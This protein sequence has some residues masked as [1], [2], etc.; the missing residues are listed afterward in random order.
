MKKSVTVAVDA[1]G[2]D[3]APAEIVKGVVDAVNSNSSVNITLVGIEDRVN[4]ELGKYEYDKSRIQVINA[5]EIIETAEHPVNAIR[6]KKDSSL[7]V[8]LNLVKNGEADAFVS[9]GSTG[10]VLVGAQAIVGRIPGVKRPPLAP[11]LPTAKGPLVLVDCGAN[12]D[13]RPDHLVLFARMGSIYSE[14]VLGIN[15]PKVG[16]ANNG[17]EEEKGNQLVKD[18]FPLLKECEDI[19]FVGSVE[20]KDIPQGNA[21]VVVCDGFVGNA[22]LKMYEGVGAT[23]ISE[24]KKSLMTSFRGKLGGLLIK[25]SL[26]QVLKKYDAT[27][28][29]GAPM[30]GLNGLVVKAHG[31][32]N[33]KEIKNAVHQCIQ[34]VEADINTKIKES[35]QND[36]Q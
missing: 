34:F 28:Y 8:A 30:L 25:P 31:S 4:L 3:N 11:V 5:T 24:I 26:K 21:D 2:G 23:L 15:K 36:N 33:A 35:L 27:E 10:A 1:M 18:T 32:S 14:Y 6:K 17:A 20:T 12:V 22:I 19:N 13:S 9:A 7:V 29:G 16:I